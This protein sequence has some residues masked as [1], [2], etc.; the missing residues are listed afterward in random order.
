VKFIIGI[1]IAYISCE[2]N[3]RL[4]YQE[5]I[6]VKTQ[7]FGRNVNGNSQQYG[8]GT[9]D[10]FQRISYADV[11]VD[12]RGSYFTNSE[13]DLGLSLQFNPKISAHVYTTVNSVYSLSG[14]GQI[15][16]G[17]GL[18]SERWIEVHFDGFDITWESKI[19]TLKVGD[20]VYQ[21]GKFNYYFYKRLSMITKESF[22]R[23]LS[24]GI[25]NEKIR[26]E[27]TAGVADVGDN[28]ADLHGLT[29]VNL[30]ENHSLE[31]YYGMRG[32]S[33]EEISSGTDFF[34]GAHYLGSIGDYLS[35]KAD[36]GYT[37]IGGTDRGNVISLLLEPSLTFNR[38]SL[39]FT[40]YALFDPDSVNK[41]A[42]DPLFGIAD[43]LMF[44]VEPGYSFNDKFAVGLPLEFHGADLEN[45]DDNAFWAV[46]TPFT[47]IL[48][49]IFSGGCGDRLWFR[50][51][52]V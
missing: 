48:L 23:G 10:I 51:L 15:P 5:R 34:A 36:V 49:R 40:G 43:E 41:L 25:G 32:S 7:N 47:S 13:L 18:P 30:N 11:W 24:Y 27:I 46:P 21:Y 19:G 6:Y 45:K 8:G 12:L 37:S 20:L 1:A 3:K 9:G 22:T 16:A 52:M 50:S 31:L 35:V 42:D 29:G 14:Q 2:K 38:F 4:N 28:V 26:Q 44:Y 17:A 33:L 39:D